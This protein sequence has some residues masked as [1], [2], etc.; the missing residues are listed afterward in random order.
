MGEANGAA[1]QRLTAS[2]ACAERF[3]TAAQH[4]KLFPQGTQRFSSVLSRFASCLWEG[5]RHDSDRLFSL[6]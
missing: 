1:A 2:P 3:S 5:R 6:A 4:Q